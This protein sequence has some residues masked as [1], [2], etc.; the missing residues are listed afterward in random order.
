M[1][2]TEYAVYV[3]Q[4]LT[5]CFVRLPDA[6]ADGS[7]MAARDRRSEVLITELHLIGGRYWPGEQ[8]TAI[9]TGRDV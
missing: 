9:Q 3:D 6:I 8:V 7:I 4:T 2:R 5:A 1:R